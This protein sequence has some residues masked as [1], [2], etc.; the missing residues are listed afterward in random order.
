MENNQNTGA[1]SLETLETPDTTV[2]G[3]S[4]SSDPN[5]NDSEK[6]GK[7]DKKSDKKKSTGNFFQD[8]IA[9]LNIYLLIFI[10]ILVVA[11][12]VMFISYQNS[13]KSKNTSATSQELSEETLKEISGNETTVGDPKQLL[14]VESNAVFS[15]KVLIRDSLDVAGAIKV[16][17][18]INLPGI[19][20]SGTSNF[21]KIEVNSLSIAG[22]TSIQG[23]LTV[24]KNLTVSGAATFSG[25]ISAPSVNIDSL[26]LNQ[27][28]QLNRHI[29]A[30]GSSPRIA[31]GSVGSGGT[32]SISGS[33]T[34]GTVTVNFGSG[35]SAGAIAT[36]TFANAF[37]GN[38]HVVITPVATLGSG[39]VGTNQGYYI[40]SRTPS[41]F[42]IASSGTPPAGSISF[43][44]IAID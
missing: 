25:T 40:T 12:L 1:E 42:T 3:G 35:A 24:Q 34:A 28:I 7:K 18:A 30:G 4:S 29:D 6:D 11:G 33:D 15:G 38:P 32:V 19:T 8:L 13:R 39:L 41:G 43:D 17:G 14:T 23:Q 21:D 10:L 31:A 36:V 26:K 44:F 20:V 22:D 5:S 2:E 9:K 27:D 16:G 37:S